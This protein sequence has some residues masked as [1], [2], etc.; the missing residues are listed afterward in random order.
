MSIDFLLTSLV[1]FVAYGKFAAA[2]RDQVISRPRV[3]ALM[4]RSFAAAFVALGARL[5]V[6]DR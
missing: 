1:V 4:R 3:L 2:M 6:T 5:A